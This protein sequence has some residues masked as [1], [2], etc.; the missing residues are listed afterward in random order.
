MPIQLNPFRTHS[1]AAY[2]SLTPERIRRW[3]ILLGSLIV[4]SMVGLAAFIALGHVEEHTSFGLGTMLAFLGKFTCDFSE[5]AFHS[6]RQGDVVENYWK[7][8]LGASIILALVILAV[9]IALGKVQEA[10][11]FGL[12][13][14]L[15]F[16]GKFTVDF[17]GWAFQQPGATPALAPGPPAA[18]PVITPLETTP[19]PTPQA[20]APTPTQ[21]INH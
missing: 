4:Y 18:P 3:E 17:T 9:L 11:S 2:V 10:S 14:I 19:P 12:T 7:I 21:A 6:G 13:P 8:T 15:G 16:L 5:W 20:A 1:D